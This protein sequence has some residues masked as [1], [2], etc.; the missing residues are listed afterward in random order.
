LFLRNGIERNLLQIIFHLPKGQIE[1][2][3]ILKNKVVI[4]RSKD[5]DILVVTDGFSRKHALIELVNGDFFITDLDSKNGV[6]IDGKKIA[7]GKKTL[8]QTFLN[9]QIGPA[10]KVEISQDLN[11]SSEIVSTKR[12]NSNVH[13]LDEFTRTVM[14]ASR[15]M[16]RAA[17]MVTKKPAKSKKQ[18]KRKIP[19][20]IL[21]LFIFFLG[22]FFYITLNNKSEIPQ[23]FERPEIESSRKMTST[24]LPVASFRSHAQNL[25]CLGPLED[26]CKASDLL[27]AKNEGGVIVGTTLIVYVNLTSFLEKKYSKEFNDLLESKRLEFL[28]MRKM[29]LSNLLY[30]FKYQSALDNIQ[31][32]GGFTTNGTIKWTIAIKLNQDFNL[33]SF[34]KFKMMSI[35]DQVLNQGEISK[36]PEI[37][38]LFEV[39]PLD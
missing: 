22:L 8:V 2:F 35:L 39:L 13:S 33:N 26:W 14:R 10:Y 36:M 19:F 27:T 4:G 1:K 15:K 9:L 6:L 38:S 29:I 25:T 11:D 32:V 17:E 16:K 5:C 28:L 23:A 20:F 18:T 3:K 34:D 7:P 37:S 24:F 21:P 12:E 31:V 30:N